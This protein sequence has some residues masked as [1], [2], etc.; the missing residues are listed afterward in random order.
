MIGFTY[1]IQADSADYYPNDDSKYAAF[2]PS[3]RWDFLFL[4]IS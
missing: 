2:L 1:D 4:K 3:C